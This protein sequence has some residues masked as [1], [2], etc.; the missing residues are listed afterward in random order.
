MPNDKHIS[1]SQLE[2]KIRSY[3]LANVHAVTIACTCMLQVLINEN[4]TMFYLSHSSYVVRTL[5]VEL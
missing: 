3:L 2:N 4:I 5:S 1:L